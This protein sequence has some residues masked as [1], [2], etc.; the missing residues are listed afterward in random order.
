MKTIIKDYKDSI[1][2][3]SLLFYH[4]RY[5]RKYSV[6]DKLAN[7]FCEVTDETVKR[8]IEKEGVGNAF[9]PEFY[10]YGIFCISIAASAFGKR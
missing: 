8:M 7:L 2:S 10:I 4:Y 5:S 3:F 9:D 6:S 1:K